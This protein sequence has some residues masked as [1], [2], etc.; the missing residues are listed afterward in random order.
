MDSELTEGDTNLEPVQASAHHA[1]QEDNDS[2]SEEGDIIC[3]AKFFQEAA[4]EYQL[5]YQ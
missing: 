3:D 4:T 5:A 2:G 1:Q